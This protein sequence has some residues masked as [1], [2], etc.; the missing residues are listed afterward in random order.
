MSVAAEEDGWTFVKGRRV[1]R[2]EESSVLSE[3]FPIILEKRRKRTQTHA[4][5]PVSVL[6]ELRR[7]HSTDN[8]LAKFIQKNFKPI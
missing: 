7:F 3:E 1:R 5:G 2:S 8:F 6:R 4:F